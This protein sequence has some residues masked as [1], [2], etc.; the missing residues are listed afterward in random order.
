MPTLKFVI[1]LN[2]VIFHI[3]HIWPHVTYVVVWRPHVPTRTKEY[4]KSSCLGVWS[5]RPGFD[6]IKCKF[7]LWYF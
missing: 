5:V 6:L 2:A 7:L 3:V 4:Y 1:I